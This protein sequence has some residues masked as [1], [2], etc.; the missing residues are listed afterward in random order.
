VEDVTNVHRDGGNDDRRAMPP[1]DPWLGTAPTSP[2]EHVSADPRTSV[3]PAPAFDDAYVD[4]APPR[5]RRRGWWFA[6]A[7][8][9]LL[10]CLGGILLNPFD[11]NAPEQAGPTPQLTSPATV[12]AQPQ[13]RVNGQAS[14]KSESSKSE[15][16]AAVA[17]PAA[18]EVVYLVSS[19]GKGEVASVQFTDQDRDI[20]SKGE[21]SL[22]WRHT[23][24]T[25]GD[26]PPLVVVAQRK[27]GGTG[28][29]T[30]SI[31]LGGKVLAT[32][33]QRGRYASPQC[34]A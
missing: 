11:G 4:D 25:V 16:R 28:P 2:I 10:G 30:C 19:S 3:D 24:R 27:Q 32:A 7:A 1:A 22:P 33:V 8:V 17:E 23:F 29:V 5:R 26:K 21:V 31:S 9:A 34:S 12:S 14:S 6:A 15:T 13:P 18:D 20:V